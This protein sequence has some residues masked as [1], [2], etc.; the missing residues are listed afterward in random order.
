METLY[1]SSLMFPEEGRNEVKT[2][3]LAES[4]MIHGYII[5]IETV[6]KKESM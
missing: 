6:L 4:E 2:S 5:S 3:L 1:F